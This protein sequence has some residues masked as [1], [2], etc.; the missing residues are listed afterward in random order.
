MLPAALDDGAAASPPTAEAPV[1]GD[2]ATPS[3]PADAGGLPASIGPWLDAHP[4]LASLL[5]V[6]AVVL[7]VGLAYLLLSRLAIPLL[8]RG[9]AAS[10]KRWDDL[11]LDA[12]LLRTVSWLLP[13]AAGWALLPLLPRLG[14]DPAKVIR[15][16]FAAAIAILCAKAFSQLLSGI[17]AI[18]ERRPGSGSRPIRSYVQLVQL[19]AWLVGA[20]VAVAVLVDRSPVILLSGLGALAAVLLLVFK[21]T[22][23]SLVAAV[24]VTSYDLVRVGDWVEAPKFGADGTVIEIGLN[25][26][27]I[28]NWDLTV[29]SVPTFKLVDESFKNWRGMSES[30]GRRI[31]RM[32]LVDLESIRFLEPSEI[33]DLG[34]MALLAEYVGSKRQE[35]AEANRRAAEAHPGVEPPERR[36]TNVGTFRAYIERYVRSR[37]DVHKGMTLLVRQLQPT[38][39]G[40][41]IEIW[42]FTATTEWIP[43]ESIQADIFDH[44]L[45]IAA[46]FGIRIVQHP[47]GGD[48]QRLGAM[49]RG[50]G[51]AGAGVAPA[52]AGGAGRGS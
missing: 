18:Y 27:K 45:A 36:L 25:V 22:I 17:N 4:L 11:L 33:E 44:L 5:E 8:R 50:D 49:L 6:A 38:A 41:P 26:V 12:P 21:D 23:L 31:K 28:R 14:P 47:T 30:G 7:A 42:C 10:R 46:R 40:L 35:I 34:R 13:L 16:A 3:D 37:A 43:Y 51:G 9:V 32:L 29:T 2:F 15:N 19:L 52:P 39:D 24:Q 1:G 48:L 20:I